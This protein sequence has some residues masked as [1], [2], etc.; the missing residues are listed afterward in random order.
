MSEKEHDR[1]TNI[2]TAA[3]AAKFPP[4]IEKHGLEKAAATITAV[5]RAF[6]ALGEVPPGCVPD[7]VNLI[8]EVLDLS[9]KLR[10]EE[11]R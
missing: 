4:L 5:G 9:D 3:F 1:E 7:A 11:V 6:E 8:R 10:P 2:L